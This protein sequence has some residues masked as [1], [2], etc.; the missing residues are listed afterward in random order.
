MK[1]MKGKIIMHTLQ[2]GFQVT[3]P[4]VTVMLLTMMSI[5]WETFIVVP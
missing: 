5:V 4:F 2:L 1:T 3:I